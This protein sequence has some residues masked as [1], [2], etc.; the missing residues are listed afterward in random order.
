MG[1]DL[2]FIPRAWLKAFKGI[3]LCVGYGLIGQMFVSDKFFFLIYILSAQFLL[4]I[5]CFSQSSLTGMFLSV[6][7]KL[8]QGFCMTLENM[9]HNLTF[10]IANNWI[11][12]MHTLAKLSPKATILF[13]FILLSQH[14]KS[15][16]YF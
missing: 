2:A 3:F 9:I 7:S 5:L 10:S 14:L 4:F 8:V 15:T 12:L 13:H 16:K 1:L 11:G 6:K